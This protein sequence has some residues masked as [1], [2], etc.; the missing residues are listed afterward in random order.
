[1]T[2]DQ[3]KQDATVTINWFRVNFPTIVTLAGVLWFMAAQTTAINSRLDVLDQDRTERSSIADRNYAAINATLEAMRGQ[4]IPYRVGQAEIAVAET[5]Q[6]MDQLQHTLL[7]QIELIRKDL[8]RLT[9]QVEVMSTRVGILTGDLDERGR[10]IG[11]QRPV[12]N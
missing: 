11:K 10:S 4:N 12:P 9:T 8:S 2:A 1:M 3:M 7:G 6:R 5:R